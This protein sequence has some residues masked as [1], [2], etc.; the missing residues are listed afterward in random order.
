M[1]V[2]LSS[3]H[4]VNDSDVPGKSAGEGES[5]TNKQASVRGKLVNVSIVSSNREP[6]QH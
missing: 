4:E 1:V 5:M 3:F 2:D 6:F